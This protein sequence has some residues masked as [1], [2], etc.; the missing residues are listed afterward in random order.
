M[1]RNTDNMR[2]VKSVTSHIQTVRCLDCNMSDEIGPTQEY[3]PSQAKRH[4][5]R[6]PGHVIVHT[7]ISEKR[8]TLPVNGAIPP[9]LLEN[10]RMEDEI[11]VHKQ[12]K[13]ADTRKANS[14]GKVSA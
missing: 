1:A 6:H 3:T 12:Q 5:G 4:A 9:A 11:Q 14:N 10:V 7:T 2:D 8:Y 13:A